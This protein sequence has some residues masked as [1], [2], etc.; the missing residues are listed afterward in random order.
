MTALAPVVSRD[1]AIGKFSR[2]AWWQRLARP[3]RESH[4]EIV[5]L[6]RY[7]IALKRAAA[8]S[9]EQQSHTAA[10]V[11][12]FE[13]EVDI[14]DLAGVGCAEH[15]PAECFSP[16]ISAEQALAAARLRLQRAALASVRPQQRLV[17][18]EPPE[19]ELVHYPYWAYYFRRRA[20]MLDAALLDAI[21]AARAGPQLKRAL[22]AALASSSP[23]RASQNSRG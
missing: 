17:M 4:L 1:E 18:L 11:G 8:T 12:A 3:P 19:I 7:R 21:T 14:L 22:L 15:E 5:Y 10:F 13:A 20:G 16:A 9:T 23:G 6:P 2:R